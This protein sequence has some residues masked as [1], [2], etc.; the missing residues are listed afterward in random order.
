[1]STPVCAVEIGITYI[2]IIIYLLY[3]NV[4]LGLRLGIGLRLGLG[5]RLGLRLGLGI[6]IRLGL[7]PFPSLSPSPFYIRRHGIPHFTR[8]Y[9]NLRE[10]GYVGYP[11][12]W[13]NFHDPGIQRFLYICI[14]MFLYSVVKHGFTRSS[15]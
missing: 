2:I 9:P 12:L 6:G 10:I 11:I 8:R 4:G 7:R 15:S 1:M 5:I 14:L 13:V 3:S